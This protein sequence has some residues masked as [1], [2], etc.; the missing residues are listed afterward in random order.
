M[1]REVEIPVEDLSMRL[2]KGKKIK[3]MPSSGSIAHISK[4]RRR[5]FIV[6]TY[7]NRTANER[8]I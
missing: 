3:F 7:N 4:P 5:I 1:G 6:A 2:L 8:R